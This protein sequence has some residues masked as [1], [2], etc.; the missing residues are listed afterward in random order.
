MANKI[1]STAASA[2]TAGG[3]SNRHL[4]VPIEIEPGWI[5][6]LVC[7]SSTTFATIDYSVDVTTGA[8]G[9]LTAN[10]V[11]GV[12]PTNGGITLTDSVLF[13]STHMLSVF[14]DATSGNINAMICEWDP[15]TH[16]HTSHTV[17]DLGITGG[18]GGSG[19]FVNMEKIDATHYLVVYTTGSAL[20]SQV[21]EVNAGTYA[22][23]TVGTPLTVATT[24][25]VAQGHVVQI[26]A[27]HY[28]ISYT[29]RN[30]AATAS[31]FFMIV[32]VNLG[33][34]DVTTA[35]AETDLGLG[36]P[37]NSYITSYCI[38]SLTWTFKVSATKVVVFYSTGD[39]KSVV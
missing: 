37:A 15:A 30:A 23:T 25:A 34:W 4:G 8:I 16:T 11:V 17:T 27:T 31:G 5:L 13:D 36:A 10:T 22:V 38:D 39:R 24:P 2:T 26:D 21:I 12:A 1:F 20:M 14:Q 32:E 35:T 3:S 7:P 33:T 18:G 9:A 19:F 28:S 29:Y 6:Q